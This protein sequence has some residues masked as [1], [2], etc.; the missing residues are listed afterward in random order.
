MTGT[1][2]A[3]L[4]RSI[5]PLPPR[6]MMTSTYC[7]MAMSW[8]TTAR[9]V[10]C[11]SCTASA[12][13]PLESSACC[14]SRASALF[15]SIASEPP[16]RMQALPLLIERLAASIVTFGRL[17]KI[18]PKTPIGTR[19]CPTRMPLGCCFMPIISPITSGMAA[20]C[21]QPW[22]TVS[23]MG[24]VSL[25]LSTMGAARP[26]ATARA[27]SFAFSA[28]KA[29]TLLRRSAASARN[30]AFLTAADARAIALE[31][32][33]AWAPRVWLYST[34]L[35]AFMPY[36]LMPDDRYFARRMGAGAAHW[37]HSCMARRCKACQPLA[38]QSA[39]FKPFT[40]PSTL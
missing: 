35:S 30:A 31:A 2:A 15:E 37:L 20:S 13:K 24:A 34:T 21:S 40:M 1:C 25:S 28:C 27:R 22:A 7:G 6:G 16:R 38:G 17:S 23:M 4:I 10:V 14:T 32:T 19:I 8:S 33:R 11:T 9:S 29:A 12:G 18:M 26:L 5:R 3:R 36:F 39:C